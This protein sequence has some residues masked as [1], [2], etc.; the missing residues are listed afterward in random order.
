MSISEN[1]LCP[2]H[3]H[4]QTSLQ[5]HRSMLVIPCNQDHVLLQLMCPIPPTTTPLEANLKQIVLL[6]TLISIWISVDLWILAIMSLNHHHLLTFHLKL[7]VR[8]ARSHKVLNHPQRRLALGT[9]HSASSASSSAILSTSTNESPLQQFVRKLFDDSRPKKC[10]NIFTK[11]IVPLQDLPQ[12][13]ELRGSPSRKPSGVIYF[14]RVSLSSLPKRVPSSDSK[15]FEPLPQLESHASSSSASGRQSLRLAS[16]TT[17]P[18]SP[19]VY[20]SPCW[21]TRWRSLRSMILGHRPA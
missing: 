18:M 9:D 2:Y 1:N 11:H 4:L 7:W 19:H 12:D 13:D 6:W 10:Q 14:K 5:M 8:S 15:S 17:D 20:A 3:L 16:K 21:G